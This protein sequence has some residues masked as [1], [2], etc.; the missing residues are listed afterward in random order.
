M[1]LNFELFK[2]NIIGLLGIFFSRIWENHLNN[3]TKEYIN[4]LWL[5]VFKLKLCSQFRTPFLHHLPILPPLQAWACKREL[6]VQHKSL[7]QDF[8][9]IKGHNKKL[10]KH[11]PK[12]G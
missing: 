2:N 4:L 9:T 12:P 8:I 3:N 10:L 6:V 1:K 7:N 11:P 5:G